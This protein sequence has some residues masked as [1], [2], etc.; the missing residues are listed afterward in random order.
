MASCVSALC[1]IRIPVNSRRIAG[2][3]THRI[4]H[5]VIGRGPRP[6]VARAPA[7]RTAHTV[8][9][10]VAL[11]PDPRKEGDALGARAKIVLT[12]TALMPPL[13]AFFLTRWP[14]RLPIFGERHVLPV[15]Y[16]G[17]DSCFLRL[18]ATG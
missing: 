10:A 8:L 15:D 3:F 5:A 1:V 13:L 11:L 6:G 2:T 9:I 14:F 18:V 7:V 12:L 4:P 16:C 17:S